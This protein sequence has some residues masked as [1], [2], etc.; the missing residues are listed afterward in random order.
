MEGKQI[1][2]QCYNFSGRFQEWMK[3]RSEADGQ[4]Y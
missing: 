3:D 1:D 2:T 4:I